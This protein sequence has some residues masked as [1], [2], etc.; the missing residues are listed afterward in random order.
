MLLHAGDNTNTYPPAATWCDAIQ[1]ELGSTQVFQC[2]AGDK[3]QR[4]HYAFNASL[5]GLALD[6]VGSPAQTVMVFETDGGWNLNGGSELLLQNPRHDR[7]VVVGFAD[8]HAEMVTE[9]RLSQL[10]WE[11]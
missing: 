5:G 9:E 2:P 6:K 8:G 3:S 1:P 4:C 11:P 10:V 7:A